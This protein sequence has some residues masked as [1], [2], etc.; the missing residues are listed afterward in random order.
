MA[1]RPAV[2]AL[3]LLVTAAQATTTITGHIYC[4]NYFEFYFNG[5]LIATDPLTFTPHNAVAVSF[6]WDGTSDRHYAIMCQDFASSSGYEYTGTSSPQLGDGAL[7]AYFSD[8]TSTSSSW[9]TFTATYGPTDASVTAGCSATNL[10]ACAIQTTTE[11][12]G[13]NLANFSPDSSWSAATEYTAAVAGWGRTPTW[14]GSKCCTATSPVTKSDLTLNSGCSVNYDTSAPTA[15]IAATVSESQ[16]LDPQSVLSESTS[17]MIWGS[18]LEKDNRML[19]TFN[20][21]SA[22]ITSAPTTSAN[23]SARASSG[24]SISRAIIAVIGLAMVALT[25]A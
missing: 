15:G 21:G 23:G 9:K 2:V 10:A 16:C 24:S 1:G 13:W 4:D 11:P 22:A 25:Q 7:M 8:G 19:F 3:F 12:T 17:S 18:S 5:E 14:D 6:S 20:A